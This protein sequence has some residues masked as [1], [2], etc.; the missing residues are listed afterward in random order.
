MQP[1]LNYKEDDEK[2][3]LLGRVFEFIENEKTKNILSR[4]G[5][6]NRS[7]AVICIKIFFISLFF[8]Y[9]VSRVIDELNAKEKLR[10]FSR[11]YD[12][13]NEYQVSE[14]FSRYK[15]YLKH[16]VQKISLHLQKRLKVK[17]LKKITKLP[18]IFFS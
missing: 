12:V 10:N 8:N 4:S 6:R 15:Y 18:I 16:F 5:F 13:P 1:G 9:E 11:I 2:F 14:Y 17:K 7:M 3:I